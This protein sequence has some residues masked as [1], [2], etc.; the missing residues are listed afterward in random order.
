MNADGDPVFGNG[1]PIPKDRRW[2]DSKEEICRGL[3]TWHV[4]R[5]I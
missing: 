3:G 4:C 2:R 1:K 5:E